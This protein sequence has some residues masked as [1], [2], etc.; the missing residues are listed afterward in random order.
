MSDN[1]M[2]RTQVY[3]TEEEHRALKALARR[4]G[5]SFA[6]TL[7]EAIDAY[8]IEHQTPGLQDAIARSFGCWQDDDDEQRSDVRT[9]RDEWEARESRNK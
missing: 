1:N 6:A 4:H 9:L 8:V 3:L 5:R 7:R 2:H